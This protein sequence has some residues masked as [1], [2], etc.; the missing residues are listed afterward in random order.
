ME[1]KM[2]F[3]DGLSIILKEILMRKSLG[4]LLNDIKTYYPKL[5]EKR[6]EA[7]VFI[8]IHKVMLTLL[9]YNY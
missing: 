5:K 9:F 1:L 6:I 7:K 4:N 2:D 8:K 3:Y